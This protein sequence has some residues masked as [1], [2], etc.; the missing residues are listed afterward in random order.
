MREIALAILLFACPLQASTTLLVSVFD[1]KTGHAVS[2]LTASDFKSELPVESVTQLPV[3]PRKIMLLIDTSLVGA[4]VQ[5]AIL[6]LINELAPG[7]QMALIGVHSSADVL[8]DFTSDK[9]LLKKAAARV[10]F[11]NSPRM[12]DALYAAIED[13]FG[14]GERFGVIVLLSAGIEGPSRTTETEVLELARRK[15]VSIFPVSL[16]SARHAVLDQLASQT[17]AVSF[18][19]RDMRK[20]SGDKV[21]AIFEAIRAAY[22]V[23][24]TGDGPLPETFKLEIKGREKLSVTAMPIGF[25]P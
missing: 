4:A 2:G 8:Q 13:G 7:D 1:S 23:T 16:G 18:K 5:P 3:E 14:K 6:P 25:K 15:G 11:A 24:I 10:K 9:E 22:L 17:G 20:A 12:L 19:L 21:R